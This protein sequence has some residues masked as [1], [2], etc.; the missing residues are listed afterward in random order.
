MRN[1]GMLAPLL[2]ALASTARTSDAAMA[3][4][5]QVTGPVV[6]VTGDMIVVQKGKDKWEIGRDGTTKTTAEPKVGDKVTVEYRMQ[7]TSIEVKPEAKK[8]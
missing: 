6:S 1:L 8:K 4:T 7:A 3:K 2:L 5:Y